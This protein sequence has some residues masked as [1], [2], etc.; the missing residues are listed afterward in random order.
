MS[1]RLSSVEILLS[2]IS[3]LL[4]ICCIGLSVVSWIS[5]THKGAEEPLQLYGR[6]VITAGVEFSD[7]LRNSSSKQFKSLAFDL[8]QLVSEAF[9][10]SDLLRFYR[11]CQVQYF[12]PGS[13]VVTFD[14]WFTQLIDMKEVEQQL[15]AGLQI[16][17]GGAL[18]IDINS[19]QITG[20]SVM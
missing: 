7:E 13:V 18:V 8:Q 12:S 20:K 11:F 3:S 14:L 4:L 17:G 16:T 2:I 9:I 10:F 19:I 15:K 5:L 1:R 6:I